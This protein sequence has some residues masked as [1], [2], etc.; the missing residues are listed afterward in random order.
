MYPEDL[1]G[2]VP[3][4]AIRDGLIFLFDWYQFKS[5]QKY[6]NPETSVEELRELL[7]N[8]E[9]IYTQNF[10]YETPPMIEELFNGY[11][12][13]NLQMEQSE[14][15]K[16]FFEMAVKHYPN[17]ASG[18]DGMVDYYMSVNDTSNAIIEAKKAFALDSSEYY[19][20]RLKELKG[21]D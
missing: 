7:R 19:S 12:Y 5:P 18:Y 8:Q 9:E 13:M 3:L 17:S 14:K 20:K 21:K 1:H 2:T 11:G 15:A 10:G 6:N 16:M 4:P